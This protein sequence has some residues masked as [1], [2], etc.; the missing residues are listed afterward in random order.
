MAASDSMTSWGA[1]SGGSWRRT[2]A[3]AAGRRRERSAGESG[4]PKPVS[5]VTAADESTFKTAIIA[6]LSE[7]NEAGKAFL[8]TIPDPRAYCH[9]PTNYKLVKEWCDW[10]DGDWMESREIGTSTPQL[11]RDIKGISSS[12]RA[13]RDSRTGD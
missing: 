2:A 10:L 9:A 11:V 5:V 8:R 6:A 13:A 3:N 1:T 4:S 7:A 12:R